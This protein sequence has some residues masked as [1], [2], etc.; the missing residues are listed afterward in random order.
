MLRTY[1]RPLIL[2]LAAVALAAS[3]SSLYVHY[4]M[5]QDPLYSS[6]CDISET[7]SCETV[8]ASE[9]G[10][11]FGVPV[12][13]GGAIWSALVLLLGLTGL[14][15]RRAEQTQ[16]VLGY[17]FLLSLVGMAAV[18][19]YAYASF[20]VLGVTCPLCAA[21]YIA[22]T[23]IFVVSALSS[24]TPAGT[25]LGRL[26]QDLGVV[27][28]DGVGQTLAVAF[29]AASIAL[30][31]LFPR[32]PLGAA[33]AD[34]A[35]AGGGAAPVLTETLTEAQ[36]EQFSL[37]IEAQT[38]ED[39]PVPAEAEGATVVIQKFNDYI[40]PSCRQT[41]VEYLPVVAKWA[42]SHPDAVKFVYRDFPLELECGPGNA[43]HFSACEA[44]VA[45]RLAKEVGREREMEAWIFENQATM[46]P[47]RVQEGL[48]Q[49][50]G[51][52]D[53]EARYDE[54]LEQVREDVQ[55]GVRL[56]VQSTPTF[57]VNGIRIEGGLRPAYLDALIEAEL[58]A[59]DA[60]QPP[61]AD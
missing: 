3:V 54:V 11:V 14:K 48:A 28:R 55:L 43:G 29:V 61:A 8:Y 1:A 37:W 33:S 45:V 2:A 21:V 27:M 35:A 46:T 25:L 57:F 47:D 16:V 30:V 19:Y 10:T 26:G 51:V 52:A 23:G 44:A 59:A 6:F 31:V 4:Q 22:V 40:C 50:A 49:I 42:A 56:S 32:D 36:R 53:F 7:V 34:V 5:L 38:R 41:Y 24:P 18:L 9:Y 12:A 39:I 60:P 13:A 17:V 20:V 15:G 58:T